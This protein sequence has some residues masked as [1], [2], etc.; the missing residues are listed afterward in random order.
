M[1]SIY[2]YSCFYPSKL[3]GCLTLNFIDCFKKLFRKNPFKLFITFFMSVNCYIVKPL[4][5][6]Y[7]YGQYGLEHPS[8]SQYR[9][10]PQI[11]FVINFRL[12]WL[13]EPHAGQDGGLH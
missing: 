13:V 4:T 7:T 2:K 3:M 11:Q 6:R 10:A 9:A 8:V 5:L 12:V 1:F